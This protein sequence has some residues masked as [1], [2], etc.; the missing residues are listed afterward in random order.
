MS[1]R[2]SKIVGNLTARANER[3]EFD[4]RRIA[5][6]C[7]LAMLSLVADAADAA[8]Q[9][10][11]TDSITAAAEDFVRAKIGPKAARTSVKAG[12]LDSRHRLALCSEALEPFLRRGAKIDVRTI[13]GVRCT[14]EKPWKVYLPVEVIVT[15]KVLVAS[16]TLPRGHLLATSD[17]VVEERDVSRL[18]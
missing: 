1:E 17:L 5:K 8:Q 18:L 9:W 14:G 13:V 12:S 15:D 7:V 16:R 2:A 10:Q 4:G 6:V 11:P 3:H